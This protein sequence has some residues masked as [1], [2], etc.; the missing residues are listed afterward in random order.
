MGTLPV[1][2]LALEGSSAQGREKDW[3]L[4]SLE[5]DGRR[6]PLGM[7]MGGTVGL[8]KTC[9]LL[10]QTDWTLRGQVLV[11]CQGLGLLHCEFVGSGQGRL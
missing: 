6:R 10:S 9:T 2:I 11:L 1:R 5:V 8:I 4:G 7:E 3:T